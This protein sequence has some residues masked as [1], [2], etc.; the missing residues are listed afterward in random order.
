MARD[1][2]DDDDGVVDQDA[3]R[4]DEREQ[5]DAIDRITHHPG[6]EEREQDRRRNDDHDDEAFPPPDGD[7]DER[8]DRDRRESEVEQELVRLLGRGF[9]VVSRDGD[10]DAGRDDASAHDLEPFQHVIGDRHRICALALGDGERDRRAAP[11]FAAL[12]ARDHPGAMLRFGGADD[13]I[14]DIL[15]VNGPSVA[16]RQEQKADVRHALKRLPGEHRKRLAPVAKRADLER[17]VGVGDF[18][19]ELVQRDAEDR[20]PF[21]VRLD[22]DLVRAAA[23]DIGRPDVV[24]FGEFMAQFLGDLKEPVVSPASRLLRSSR[25]RERDDRDVIDAAANDQRF[26][27]AFR[28]IADVRPDLLVHAERRDVLV[29]ADQ[30]ARRHHDAVVVGLRIDVLD[31]V[32][33]L[34]DVFER[35]SHQFDGLIGFVTVGRND[36]VDHRHA[37]LRLFLARKRYERDGAGDQRRQQKE[38]RQRRLDEGAGENPRDAELHGVTISSPSLRPARISTVWSSREPSWTTTS[39]P[40]RS[41]TKSIPAR[42]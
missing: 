17:T 19:D 20:Q 15:D 6:G 1:I 29:R 11:Q 30:K 41:L 28:Q 32:D 7:G 33:A 5:A 37:D 2:L 26:G 42:R 14:R 24:D 3:D 18:V 36:D 35:T 10:V 21:G 34:D 27:N 8:D 9:P 40:F 12:A 39:S 31:A 25:Q 16:G 38:R 22:A 4:E 13:D 23:D